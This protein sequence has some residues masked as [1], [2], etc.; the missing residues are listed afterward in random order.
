MWDKDGDEDE[1]DTVCESLFAACDRSDL[2]D[3]IEKP[4][5]EKH[6]SKVSAREVKVKSSKKRGKK[7]KKRS[8]TST[9]SSSRSESASTPTTSNSSSEEACG[10]MRPGSRLRC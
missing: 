10:E 4:A 5:R 2:D 9:S 3:V 8:S 1:E 6:G 7:S